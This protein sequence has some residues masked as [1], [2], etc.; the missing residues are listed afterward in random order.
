MNSSAGVDIRR[1]RDIDETKQCARLM[2]TS[3]PWLTLGRNY[4]E[5][6]ETLSDASKEVHVAVRNNALV[7]FIILNLNGAFVGY[8]QTV[9][10]VQECRGTGIGSMLLRF[11]EQRILRD[12]PNVFMC[13]SS[14]N[15]DAQ[16]LYERLGY[17][18]IGE[19][20][21]YIVPG[22]SEILMRKTVA[23]LKQFR[24]CQG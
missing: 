11:A 24:K 14:F 18:V 5:S 10:V 9:F 15:K 3:E 8:I 7:G 21:D 23:P 2:A 13:V 6:L 4:D 22:Q 16:R 19:L 17:E 12:T 1:L 20:R